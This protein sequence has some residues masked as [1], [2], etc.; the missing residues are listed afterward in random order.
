MRVVTLAKIH[1]FAF[2]LLV[3]SDELKQDLPGITLLF[4]TSDDLKQDLGLFLLKIV[5]SPG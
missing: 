4:V 3:T 2:L 1:N 5:D